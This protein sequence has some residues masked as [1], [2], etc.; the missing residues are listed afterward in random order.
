MKQKETRGSISAKLA[1]MARN[2]NSTSNDE[3]S[4]IT[5][6]DLEALLN[7]QRESFKADVATLIRESTES[8]KSSVDSQGQ[9]V[10]SFNSRLTQTEALAGENFGKLTEMEA[11]VK[12]LQSQCGKLLDKVDDL[13]NRSRRSNL[14]IINVPEGS[15]KGQDPAKFV[16]DLLMM[17]TGSK[18]FSRPPEIERAHRSLHRSGDSN[19][20]KP[21]AFIVKFLCFQ[22]KEKVL[23][24]ARKHTMTY[25]DS[26]LRVY[27]DI[28]AELAKQRASFNGIKNSLY[29]KGIKFH[30]LYPAHLHVTF[31]DQDYHFD[32]P[33]KAQ[34]AAET[35]L[36]LRCLLQPANWN[37]LLF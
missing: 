21:R 2:A 25:H 22:E 26:E 31:Q 12:A 13:E 16:S 15:E 10:A 6:S 29:L 5:K 20:G 24:W 11:T 35:G 18:V 32:S 4:W 28:S 37:F 17:V 9:Q 34:E 33:Q 7:D 3:G 36:I 30:L 23:R 14:R 19:T 8:L 27:P 1:K